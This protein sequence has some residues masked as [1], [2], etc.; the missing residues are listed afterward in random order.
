MRRKVKSTDEAMILHERYN[1]YRLDCARHAAKLVYERDGEWDTQRVAEQ[2]EADGRL[3]ASTPD[4]AER[5]FM[6]GVSLATDSDGRVWIQTGRKA[7]RFNAKRN[8]HKGAEPVNIWTKREGADLSAW[9]EY[10]PFMEAPPP[11]A[12]A[13]PSLPFEASTCVKELSRAKNTVLLA[14]DR[15][16]D[17]LEKLTEWLRAC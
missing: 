15:W 8:V 7:E 1:W 9:A 16:S 12:P 5:R 11:L 3:P 14:G 17:E 6:G 10:P 13:K 4:E 2:L